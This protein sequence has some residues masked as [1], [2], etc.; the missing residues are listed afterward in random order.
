LEKLGLNDDLLL[1]NALNNS[2]KVLFDLFLDR[3]LQ[4]TFNFFAVF[5]PVLS[6]DSSVD[7]SLSHKISLGCLN[8]SS[9]GH[10][11]NLVLG[12]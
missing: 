4:Q 9:E 8:G 11:V 2:V 10:E 6:L 1:L 7:N 12:K 5:E 3:C